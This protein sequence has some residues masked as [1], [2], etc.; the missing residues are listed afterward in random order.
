MGKKEK[1]QVKWCPLSMG[2]RL[3]CNQEECA[4]WDSLAKACSILVLCWNIKCFA[5]DL[6]HI[7]KDKH[8]W[9]K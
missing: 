9:D 3:P 2:N 1:D 4:W 8:P 6:L 7:C 5:E